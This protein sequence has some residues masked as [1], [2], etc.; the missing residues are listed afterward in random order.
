MTTKQESQPSFADMFGSSKDDRK[1]F[2]DRA[3]KHLGIEGM[4][5][6]T[7]V[8]WTCKELGAELSRKGVEFDTDSGTWEGLKA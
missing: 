1:G 4:N 2:R 6:A 3:K 8:G 7:S 5:P